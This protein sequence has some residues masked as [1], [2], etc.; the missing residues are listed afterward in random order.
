MS[1]EIMQQA[2]DA[3][4]NGKNVR[5][6]MGNTKLQIAFENDAIAALEAELAKP[7]QELDY[8]PE[9]TTQEMKIAYAAGWF[10][11]LEVQRN[12][13]PEQEPVAWIEHEWSGTG[14]RHLQWDR[15]KPT[16]RDEV[17]N[18]LWTPLYTAPP[19][20]EWLSLT[21]D[22]IYEVANGKGIRWGENYHANF[23]R[24]IEAK[25]REKNGNS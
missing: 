20:R 6:G 2:L 16:L 15:R 8:P 21:D 19:K 22:E 7:E 1:R 12:K 3:L 25:L 9:C 23:A 24:A 10:K 4:K 17:L 18:P 13:Q 5:Q 14:L 11:A